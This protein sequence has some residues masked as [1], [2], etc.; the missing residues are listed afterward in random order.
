MIRLLAALPPAFAARE[1]VCAARIATLHAAW[2]GVA[3]RCSGPDF[4]ETGGAVLSVFDGICTLDGGGWDAQELRE[5]L[6]LRGCSVLVCSGDTAQAVLPDAA[7]SFFPV[8]RAAQGIQPASGAP[9]LERTPPLAQVYRLL[10]D[11]FENMKDT[12][13]HA[14]YADVSLRQ[15]RGIA[16]VWAILEDGNVV[17]TAGIYHQ[18]AH[19][20]V[21]GSVA[22]A[23]L[24]RGRG[25]ASALVAAL[26]QSA[27]QEGK[28]VLIA[29]KN[30]RAQELY[31]RQ[32]FRCEAE[33]AT[34]ELPY[35]RHGAVAT[36]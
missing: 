34:L 22:T 19:V 32:G 15:R 8:L 25:L 31:T 6:R 1:T 20:A 23:V 28:A 18:N 14:W 13:F 10:A 33:L 24:A 17:S 35:G 26:A 12:E 4:Y 16:R 29:A 5:F 27:Q 30:P 3:A 2:Q 7:A 21:I 9:A 11:T 36:E